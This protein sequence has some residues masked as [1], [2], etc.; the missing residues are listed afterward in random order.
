[1]LPGFNL[2]PLELEGAIG[3]QQIRKL[4]GII[5]ERRKNGK[6]F[7]QAMSSHPDLMIQTE[8]GESSW[9]GFSLIIKPSSNLTRKHLIAQLNQ[10]G[11]E[12]RPIVAGNFVKNPVIK[13]FD[14]EV[15]GLLPNANHLDTHG[16]FIGN[17]PYPIPSAIDALKDLK[18]QF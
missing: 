5:D 12:C 13:Y 17:H 18:F 3:I 9:F 1:M 15:E 10:A 8:I 14:H 2:R 7:Q 16:L 6:L 4:P 11:F